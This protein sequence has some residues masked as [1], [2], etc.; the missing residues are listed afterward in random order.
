[1]SQKYLIDPSCRSGAF[2]QN[3]RQIRNAFGRY[4]K[5]ADGYF[6]FEHKRYDVLNKVQEAWPLERNAIVNHTC[7][8]NNRVESLKPVKLITFGSQLPGL[9]A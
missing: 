3:P 8:K 2:F 7:C 4:S 5:D 1:M 6:D 9:V